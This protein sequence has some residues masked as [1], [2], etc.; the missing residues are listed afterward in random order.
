MSYGFEDGKF[1]LD[2]TPCYRSVGTPREEFNNRAIAI[3]KNH[4]NL[5]L[6][7][8]GGT[9]SQVTYRAFH[10]SNIP[11]TCAFMH[12][13]GYN[14]NEYKNTKK[15]LA[16]YNFDLIVI[17][18]DPIAEKDNILGLSNE[19]G[20][21]PNQILHSLFLSKLPTDCLF[22]EAFNGP[23]LYVKD[24]KFYL[25]E[26]ANSVEYARLRA[27]DQLNPNHNVIGFEKEEHILLSVLKDDTLH[28]AM[29]AWDY[30]NI[31]GL[32]YLGEEPLSVINYW[33]L[34][35]KPMFFGK[36]WKQDID[37]YPKFQG[38]ENIDYIINGM[39]H[40]YRENQIFIN[41][42]NLIEVL[43]NKGVTVRYYERQKASQ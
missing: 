34:F 38:C 5:I 3:S 15:Q 12:M 36:H 7:L 31:P 23:D 28:A 35:I 14:D 29:C 33:D 11:V 6:S 13:P 2:Y 17:T 32:S 18:I 24:K 42:N 41:V 25:F 40:R 1:Y 10:D 8:S 27:Y 22:T 20:I 9:D 16:K 4:D 39:E 37:Y 26:T 21:P 43:E 19:L 30:Y